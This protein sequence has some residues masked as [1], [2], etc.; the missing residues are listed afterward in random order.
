MPSLFSQLADAEFA[1]HPWNAAMDS[2]RIVPLDSTEAA[3]LA[4]FF[5]SLV[6]GVN[7]TSRA[8]VRSFGNTPSLTV[9]GV[10]ADIL[11]R[12]QANHWFVTAAISGSPGLS[13]EMSSTGT[14][15]RLWPASLT[16]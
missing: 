9:S 15:L 16:R 10:S 5:L 2:L 13:M 11:V 6:T 8:A 12:A 7:A 1:R 14:I 3:Q 4:R